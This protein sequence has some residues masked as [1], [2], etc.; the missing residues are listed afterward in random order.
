M[1]LIQFYYNLIYTTYDL[2]IY[3]HTYIYVSKNIHIIIQSERKKK[4][5]DVVEFDRFHC[6]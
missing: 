4:S 6:L 5:N 3:N 1:Y 2:Q